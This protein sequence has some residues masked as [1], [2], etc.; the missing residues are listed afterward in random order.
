MRN[1][2]N[3]LLKFISIVISLLV[4]A[5]AY[6]YT[7]SEDYINNLPQNTVVIGDKAY[8]ISH[9]FRS[10]LT[11]S[12]K[13]A[14]AHKCNSLKNTNDG[15]YYSI[16]GINDGVWKN[17]FSGTSI[18]SQDEQSFFTGL[19]ENGLKY[20]DASNKEYTFVPIY[21]S[22]NLRIHFKKPD[23]WASPKLYYYDENKALQGPEWNSS[24][25]MISE[26]NSWYYYDLPDEW[27]TAATRVIFKDDNNQIPG[28]NQPGY[29]VT[30]E[31]WY[32]NGVLSYINPYYQDTVPPTVNTNLPSGEYSGNTDIIISAKDNA[33]PFPQIYYA[34]DDEAQT[35]LYRLY[36]GSITLIE[37]NHELKYYAVD[38]K[39][40]K[41]E[42]VTASYKINASNQEPATYADNLGVKYMKTGS[43]FNLFTPTAADVKLVLYDNQDIDKADGVEYQMVKGTGDIWSCKLDGDLNGKFYLFKVTNNGVPQYCLDPYSRSLAHDGIKSAVIDL[44]DTNPDGWYTT[45]KP[46]GS[47][48]AE[49]AIMYE[50]HV[51]DF[52][53]DVDSG[54][55]NK[56]KY[57]AFTEEGTK[58]SEGMSTGIDYLKSLGITHVHLLPTYDFASVK[59]DP[60]ETDPNKQFNW[61]YDPLN[62]TSPEGSYSTNPRDPV[63]RVKEFKEMVESLHK[64]NI[65]VIL[66]VVFNHTADVSTF[67]NIAPGYYY[68]MDSNNKFIDQSGCGNALNSSKPM[69]RKLI[70]DTLK[71]WATEY[72]VDGFRFD[73]A[74]VIDTDTLKEASTELHNI[75]PSIVLYG[76][77]WMG[78][79]WD[80]PHWNK[81]D[82][83]GSKFAVFNDTFRDALKGGG[84]D[85]ISASGYINAEGSGKKGAVMNGIAGSQVNGGGFGSSPDDTLNYVDAHDNLILQD[86]LTKTNSGDA[87]QKKKIQEMTYAI[88]LTSQGVPFITSGDEML[89]S[90]NLNNN[91]YNAPD[92]INQ[93]KWANESTNS[94]VA[95]YFKGLIQLRKEHPA[96]RMTNYTDINSHLDWLDT[97]TRTDNVIDFMLK[98]NANGDTWKNIVVIFNPYKSDKTMQLPAGNWEVVGDDDE[99]GTTP[100]K[101][102]SS[103][104]CGS[105]TLKPL[106]TYVLHQ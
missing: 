11:D 21:T 88:L 31:C 73:L 68:K 83:N 51:R 72:K 66:D 85:E 13:T 24:P 12:E 46:S 60:V 52:S 47:Y 10:D 29:L 49:D 81:G 64:N 33:D 86:K 59:E 50:L 90:K 63:A 71:Y 3:K 30:K 6:N 15:V 32:G 44:N 103:V 23:A 8:S 39:G 69:V 56:G 38:N 17:I 37:G 1:Y 4:I 27:K 102:G 5:T 105:I 92:S 53:T 76:E 48:N 2:S 84:D 14:I 104:L 96:F 9:L 36:S 18:Q 35:G 55:V 20:I 26:G 41:S 62:Y 89:R 79:R 93:I 34:L 16:K 97:N 42:I 82:M 25:A 77:P 101:T 75:D 70:L 80:T 40:N 65:K 100:V 74:S 7:F 106:S 19:Y 58:S 22:S 94:D 43:E 57:L 61:G 95:N 99:I 28:A 78:G 67:E 45:P 87:N 91:S 98:D 54:M